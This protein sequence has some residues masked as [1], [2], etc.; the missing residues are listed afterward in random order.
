MVTTINQ[1][2]AA[3]LQKAADLFPEA[4]REE[5]LSAEAFFREIGDILK[6]IVKYIDGSIKKNWDGPN[7]QAF[8]EE[9]HV[10]NFD[11]R[12]VVVADGVWHENHNCATQEGGPILV[13]TRKGKWILL[14]H[15]ES[16]DAYQSGSYWGRNTVLEWDP[17][18]AMQLFNF[19]LYG[20][21][22]GV[23]SQKRIIEGVVALLKKEAE[24][25]LKRLKAIEDH[26]S[27]M[28][29]ALAVYNRK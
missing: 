6:P 22:E 13:L 14:E 27:A 10:E 23:L 4:F 19:R 8:A 9:H 2:L 17:L 29:A 12:G 24:N 3:T 16:G 20:S 26:K 25:R 15:H 28:E 18:K 21:E 1:E 11:F 5:C 7:G